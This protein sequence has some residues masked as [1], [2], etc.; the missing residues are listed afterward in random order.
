MEIDNEK[1]C[2]CQLSQHFAD[3]MKQINFRNYANSRVS[4]RNSPSAEEYIVCNWT[5]KMTKKKTITNKRVMYIV[6]LE[7]FFFF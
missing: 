5:V 6:F 4:A 2:V 1:N 7:P 3:G